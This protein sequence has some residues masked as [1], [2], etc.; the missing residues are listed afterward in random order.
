[1]ILSAFE[2]RIANG[3]EVEVENAIENVCR[4]MRF[5]IEDRVAG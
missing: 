3:R 2:E 4:I 1:M 5:R